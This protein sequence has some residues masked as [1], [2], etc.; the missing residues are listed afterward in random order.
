MLSNRDILGLLAKYV[1]FLFSIPRKWKVS[2]VIAIL[3]S[4]TYALNK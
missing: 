2:T 4:C 1:Y 3:D